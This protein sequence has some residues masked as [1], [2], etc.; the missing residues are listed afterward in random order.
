MMYFIIK[1]FFLVIKDIEPPPPPIPERTYKQPDE[2]IVTPS[3]SQPLALPNQYVQS[4]NIAEG[5][6]TNII[7]F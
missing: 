3:R 7:R 4:T 6:N 1:I 5:N 2:K